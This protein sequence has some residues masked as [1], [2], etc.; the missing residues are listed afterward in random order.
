MLTDMPGVMFLD[1]VFNRG[2]VLVDLVRF[3]LTTSSMPWKR[4]P[5]CATGPRVGFFPHYITTVSLPW[6]QWIAYKLG[7]CC[8][9]LLNRTACGGTR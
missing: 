5:N 6:T 7:I 8:V 1:Q 9:N 4:A 3:E 2:A